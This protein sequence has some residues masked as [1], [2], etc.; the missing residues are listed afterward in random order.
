[1]DLVPLTSSSNP[2]QHDIQEDNIDDQQC[3][4]NFDASIDKVVID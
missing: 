4:I 2:I 1:M 3:I